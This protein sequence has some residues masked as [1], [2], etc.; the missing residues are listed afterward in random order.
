MAALLAASLGALLT[1]GCSSL[2]ILPA[3]PG[4]PPIAGDWLRDDARSDDFDSK[5]VLL[6]KDRQQRM[7]ARRGMGSDS[8]GGGAQGEGGRD[9]REFDRLE[10][11][12]EESER[13]RSRVIEDL[14]PPHLLHIRGEAGGEA[15]NM[16]HEAETDGRRYLPGQ[17]VSRIDDSGAAQINCGWNHQAFEIHA[18]YVH[19]ATRHWRYEVE[20]GSGMLLVHFEVTDP[21]IGHLI[22]ASRYQRQAP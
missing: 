21:E 14:R 22:L 8:R 5:L 7:R 1:S 6:L 3:S 12:Q 9:P 17:T 15:I 10:L 13:F 11:P 19:R 4:Q 16:M 20:P 18:Q 2:A